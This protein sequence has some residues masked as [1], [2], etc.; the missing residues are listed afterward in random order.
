MR[1]IALADAGLTGQDEQSLFIIITIIVIISI[2]TIII[3]SIAVSLFVDWLSLSNPNNN[4]MMRRANL[5]N[6]NGYRLVVFHIS[7]LYDALDQIKL[8]KLRICAS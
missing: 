6:P 3:D 1:M 7:L 4:L 8:A 2:I 5:S